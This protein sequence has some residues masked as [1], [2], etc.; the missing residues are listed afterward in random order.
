MNNNT[1]ALFAMISEF[2]TLILAV[3]IAIFSRGKQQGISQA[4][5]QVMAKQLGNT[6]TKDELRA[7]TERLARIEGMFTF[8]LKDEPTK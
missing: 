4:D 2:G 3:I 7:V 6:A 8:R 1:I 5:M